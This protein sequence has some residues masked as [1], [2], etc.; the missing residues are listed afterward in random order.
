MKKVLVTIYVHPEYYPPTLN[1]INELS[2]I[3]DEVV[4][5][6]RNLAASKWKFP[7]NV[8]LKEEG[9][10]LGLKESMA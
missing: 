8:S 3:F 9:A 6:T 5:V 1:A 7:E 2:L 10:L 4:V